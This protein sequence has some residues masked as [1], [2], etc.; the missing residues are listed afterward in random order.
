MPC[1]KVLSQDLSERTEGN[2][3]DASGP[4]LRFRVGFASCEWEVVP[5]TM[6]FIM[7]TMW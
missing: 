3:K 6:A 7:L 1:F 2:H 5:Q 4:Q